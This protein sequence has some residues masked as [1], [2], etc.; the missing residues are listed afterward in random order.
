MVSPIREDRFYRR[1]LVLGLTMA[2]TVILVLFTLL[3]LLGL[4]IERK[5]REIE[6]LTREN[7]TLQEQQVLLGGVNKIDDLF[8]ELK[9]LRAENAQ[10]RRNVAALTQEKE[11]MEEDLEAEAR[12]A[13]ELR[14]LLAE[15]GFDARDPDKLRAQI[16]EARK[17]A[18]LLQKARKEIA[19]LKEQLAYWQRRAGGRSN[20][21]PP[22]WIHPETKR[23]EYIF[24]VE[25]VS[26]GLIVHDRDIPQRRAEKAALP[27]GPVS[28]G[29]VLSG[30]AFL[31]QT[32]ALFDVSEERECRFFVRVFDRTGAAEKDAYKKHMSIVEQ[33][34]YK[35][36]VK[37]DRTAQP[38]R[39]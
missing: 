16:T 24:D 23:V 19:T 17:A 8:Q 15:S 3:L 38:G 1:G 2:E 22:C 7:S 21:L 6:R 27:I 9:L 5:N 36:E 29:A 14:A 28:F 12:A 39:V 18:D 31:D 13:R 32:R 25:L 26:A 10:L 20:E 37:D 35:Y 4:F 33:H 34:F 11:A 30:S